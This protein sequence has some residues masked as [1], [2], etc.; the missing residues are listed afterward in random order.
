MSKS[1]TN[2]YTKLKIDPDKY[3]IGLLA[4]LLPFERI[5][6]FHAA[7]V[8]VR[9]SLFVGAVIIVRAIWLVIRKDR[10]FSLRGPVLPIVLFLLWIFI[11]IP[12]SINHL[13]AAQVFIFT[14]FV[15]LV[16][17]AISITYKKDYLGAI[18]KALFVGAFLTS[19][20]GIFQ[21]FGDLYGLPQTITG[22]ATRY[23]WNLFGYAR[24]QSTALEPLYFASYLLLPIALAAALL[25]FSKLRQYK[26]LW[27]AL[28]VYS[29]VLFL[30]VS[31]GGLLGY[32]GMAI[33]MIIV[34]AT[35]PKVRSGKIWQTLG[36]VVV[37][38][39]CSLLIIGIF[40]KPVQNTQSQTTGSTSYVSHVTDF[41]ENSD[42][43][44]IS[45]DTAIGLIKKSPI[46]GFGPGQYG[47]QINNNQ[48]AYFG[49]PIVNNE[50]LEI[51][52]E[53]GIVG[54][55]F[56]L[57][58]FVSLVYFGVK[59]LQTKKWNTGQVI[60]IGLLGY[61]FA[62]AIQYQTFS[63]LYIIQLWFAIGLLMAV[64]GIQ[65]GSQKQTK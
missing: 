45:R 30:T 5:P 17:V 41:N 20:F 54:F 36:V 12:G 24:P 10:T 53:T 63:T 44:A 19:L 25:L 64:V 51:L 35:L 48:Q 22:L 55:V 6:S 26:I 8:T 7:G 39:L 15:A 32:I 61:I 18:L 57:S 11:L 13:R 60:T 1:I 58:F 4:F 2:F 46:I 43:R 38:Y 28:F 21:Y 37:A 47:P 3:L 16:A 9:L 34:Y 40:H 31:R 62:E 33:A 27:I 52:A 14:S 59:Y 56:L 29:L 50:P 49:W 42:S 65:N 23:K